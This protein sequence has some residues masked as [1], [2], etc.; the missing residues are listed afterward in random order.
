MNW[1]KWDASTGELQRQNDDVKEMQR[2]NEDF[3]KRLRKE[4]CK[5]VIQEANGIDDIQ[6]GT[7]KTDSVGQDGN[8]SNFPSSASSPAI[9]TGSY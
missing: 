3:E 9:S 6:Q 4:E 7:I 5:N 8:R 2:Q 1:N